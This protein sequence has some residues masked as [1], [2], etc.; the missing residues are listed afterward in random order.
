MT[1]P[2]V[3]VTV[4]NYNY[5]HYLP[6][7]I[8]SILDQ[9]FT[10]FELL[11]IDNAST[12]NS[13]EVIRAFM[14][15]D[16]RIRLIAHER[17]MGTHYSLRESCDLAQ[18]TYRLHVDADDWI[19][20]RRAIEWQVN[21][22]QSQPDIALVY[23]NIVFCDDQGEIVRNIIHHDQ[24]VVLPGEIAIEQIMRLV[25]HSGYMFRLDAYHNIGG[26]DPNYAY[27]DDMKL[28]MDLCS[29]GKVGYIRRN[30]Y[31]TRDHPNSLVKNNVRNLYREMNQ[32][33]EGVFSTPIAAKLRNREHLRIQ[34][35]QRSATGYPMALIFSNHYRRGWTMI[36][37]SA[38]QHPIITL[39]QRDILIM[40]LRTLVG[41]RGFEFLESLNRRFN[42]TTDHT[43]H[44]DKTVV[45]SF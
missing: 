19:M 31:A 35:M 16:S 11:I 2:L 44:E 32:I 38:K 22:I 3:S 27:A 4:T 21:M 30:L 18:G 1:K 26:Y 29:Q 43:T 34:T 33:L 42:R 12:D 13:L 28:W 45:R 17:N 8:Q 24:D 5:A 9:T 20:D 23:S 25:V 36:W 39:F 40:L 37:D 10:D 7:V 15:R 14:Q 41:Q 6:H